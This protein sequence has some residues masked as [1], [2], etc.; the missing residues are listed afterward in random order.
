MKNLLIALF[1][2]AGFSA[3]SQT[4]ADSTNVVYNLITKDSVEE[5]RTEFYGKKKVVSIT[6][7]EDKETFLNVKKASF[8]QRLAPLANDIVSVLVKHEDLVMDQIKEINV[9]EKQYDVV[10][11]DT[12]NLTT[13]LNCEFK[14]KG[15]D[16]APRFKMKEMAKGNFLQFTVGETKYKVKYNNY[17][18]V[19]Y[20]YNEEPFTILVPVKQE[21]KRLVWR[22][23]NGV[24][25]IQF[26]K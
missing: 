25:L 16:K 14:F 24:T 1:L 11:S 19:I 2:L 26:F 5:I 21:E 15:G 8:S 20:D 18:L 9:A 6:P 3:F 12:T 23:L 7:V 17:I 10:L 4:K 22:S 13:F